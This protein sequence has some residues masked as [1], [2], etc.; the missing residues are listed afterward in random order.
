MHEYSVAEEL[1]RA[2]LA[3]LAELGLQGE[4]LE[5]VHL[6]KG[7]LRLLGDEALRQAY[8][9]LTLETPLAGSKLVL[10]EVKAEIICRDCGYH[11]PAGYSDDQIYHFMA[12]ILECPRC[13]GPVVLKSGRELELVQ[14]VVATPEEAG[15]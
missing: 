3:E 1:V 9:V 5:E 4:Q 8:E 7:E 12:P 6:R 11:G 10:E 13:H 14:L 2:V 15:R